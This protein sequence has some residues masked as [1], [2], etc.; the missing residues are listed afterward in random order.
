M[1]LGTLREQLLYPT[2]STSSSENGCCPERF[3][4]PAHVTV[5]HNTTK[6]CLGVCSRRYLGTCVV[7]AN[8][9][10]L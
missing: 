9:R 7:D 2:W 4:I 3:T 6:L 5:D 1:V 10:L 8:I